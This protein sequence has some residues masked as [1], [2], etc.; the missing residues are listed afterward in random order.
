MM[1]SSSTPVREANAPADPIPSSRRS[2]W[3]VPSPWMIMA[4][5]SSSL[6]S[7]QRLSSRSMILIFIRVSDKVLAR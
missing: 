2:L 5:G 7:L 1:F 4:P 6:S 3:S